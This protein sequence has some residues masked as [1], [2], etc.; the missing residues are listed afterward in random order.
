MNQSIENAKIK[1]F[2]IDFIKSILAG[3]LIALAGTIYLMAENKIVGTFLFSFGLITIVIKKYNLY[4]GKIGYCEIGDFLNVLNYIFGNFIGTFIVSSFL[5][6]TK[7]KTILTEKVIPICEN[8]INND[9][10]TI[11]ILSF[12][13][14]VLMYL[15]VSGYKIKD[16]LILLMLPVIIFIMCG[17]EHSVANMFYFTLGYSLFSFTPRMLLVLLVMI[18][19][20][21]IGAICFKKLEFLKIEN[22]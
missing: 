7:Y 2:L 20:N 6:V 3:I 17:F 5:K 11:F 9:L 10:L 18:F 1:N 4:T 19:G 8:K 13:C 21:G 22:S 16:N 12:F 14:G 15:A